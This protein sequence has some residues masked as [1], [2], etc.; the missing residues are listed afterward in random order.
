M[1]DVAEVSGPGA[2]GFQAAWTDG[3]LQAEDGLHR[4]EAI[5]R[6]LSQEGF[7]DVVCGRADVGGDLTAAL[8]R[9]L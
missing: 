1:A 3:L 2:S 9:A 4:A 6:A 5:Q 8:W 7:H